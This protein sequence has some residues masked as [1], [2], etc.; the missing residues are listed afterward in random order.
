ML[1]ELLAFART[2]ADGAQQQASQATLAIEVGEHMAAVGSETQ[3]HTLRLL[4]DSLLA[5][6]KPGA[7][8]LWQVAS[9][10]TEASRL[11]LENACM[12]YE[13]SRVRFLREV[14]PHR[15]CCILSSGPGN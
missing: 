14:R 12:H 8:Y 6:L 15:L 10:H 11:A 1:V 3:M 2:M 13:E 5:L 4:L 9:K 7:T